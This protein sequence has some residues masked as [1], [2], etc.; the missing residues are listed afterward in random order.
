[1]TLFAIGNA[2]DNA[3]PVRG[4]LCV[5]E[6]LAPDAGVAADA[7]TPVSSVLASCTL[8]A[9]PTIAVDTFEVGLYGAYAPFENDRRPKIF[10]AIAA[11][12]SDLVCLANVNRF[13]DQQGIAAA[14][15]EQ[16]PYAYYPD[17]PTSLDTKP[18]DP[19]T[20]DGGL[21]PPS[22]VPPCAGIDASVP[23]SI[24]SCVAGACASPAN[25]TGSIATSNCLLPSCAI[26]FTGLFLQGPEQDACFDCM[27]YDL[28]SEEPL[29]TGETACTGDPRPPFAFDGATSSMMLSHYPLTDQ[30]SYILPSTGWRHSVL[31]AAVHF[32]D[33]TLDFYC[34][35]LILPQ[36]DPDVP[37]VGS[38][39]KDGVTTLPDGG[40]VTE[41]GWQDEQDLQVKRAI[42]FIQENSKKTGR[43]AI[44]AGYWAATSQ[45]S[46]AH[47][48]VIIPASSPE[49]MQALDSAFTRAEP[50]DYVPQCDYCPA[51][52]NVYDDTGIIAQDETVFLLGFEEDSTTDDEVWG[53]DN[54]VSLHSVPFEPAP[55]GGVGPLSD[56]YGR[57][58]RIIRPR[59]PAP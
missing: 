21:P 27:L 6:P 38:Y 45:E 2:G 47:G 51:P 3:H 8:S 46:D 59:V 16:F 1:M 48:N 53:Q 42:A 12:T 18:A 4:M 13:A 14:A 36:I 58:V 33:Q 17:P 15:K 20:I 44:I 23:S 37:Y 39:G 31:Y 22:T 10:E 52:Q 56:S 54:V 28:L 9:L 29:E 25:L 7:G 40:Q 11:R 50:P 55:S 41:N 24:Y 32:E 19:R 57:L 35:T 30:Q 43:P 5:D 34:V 26:Q 49:V